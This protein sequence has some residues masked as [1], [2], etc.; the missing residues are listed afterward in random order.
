MCATSRICGLLSFSE[1][2]EV[3]VVDEARVVFAFDKIGI[4]EEFFVKGDGGLDA[5]DDKFVE[6]AK[7]FSDACLAGFGLGDEFGDEGVVIG[8]DDVAG[9]GMGIYANAVPFRAVEG[10]DFAGAWSEVIRGI[11]GVDAAFDDVHFGRWKSVFAFDLLAGGDEDLF[12]DEVEVEE[13]FGHGVFYLD[14][15]IHFHEIEVAVFVEEEFDG[16]EAFVADGFACFDSGF[17]HLLAEFFGQYRGGGFFE[18]FLV[19][20][21]DGT[22]AFAEVDDI[23]VLV[24]GDL[25]FDV[26]RLFDVFFDVEAA[27]S[28][29]GLSFLLCDIPLVF[30]LVGG[31]DDAHAFSSTAGGGFEDDGIANFFGD[32][33]GLFKAFDHAFRAGD[34]GHAGFLHG[35]LSSGLVAHLLDHLWSGADKFYTVIAADFGK[36]GV[37]GEKSVPGV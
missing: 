24:A 7:H 9:V 27:I 23:A 22:I 20:S 6:G 2:F 34:D 3:E 17:A 18:E 36:F 12:F 29:G 4:L 13:F 19:A 14:A 8:G 35:L 11:F 25:D 31:V 26:S 21:L 37:F 5:F 15:G 30:E 16:A 28:E 33:F 1:G 32:G 10:F